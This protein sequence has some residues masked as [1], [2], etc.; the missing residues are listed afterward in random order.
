MVVHSLCGRFAPG[1]LLLF[2]FACRAP[3]ES[4]AR[5]AAIDAPTLC[6]ISTL[7]FEPHCTSCHSGG[8]HP[9]LTAAGA[10]GIVGSPATNASKTIVVAGDPAASLL[11]RKIAGTQGP[12]EGERM[13]LRGAA[14]DDA[15]IDLVERWIT[16]GAPITCVDEGPTSRPSEDDDE[17]AGDAPDAPATPD[18]P[19]PADEATSDDAP[20]A[21]QPPPDEAIADAGAPVDAGVSA[22][23]VTWVG[24]VWPLVQASCTSCHDAATPAGDLDMSSASVGYAALLGAPSTCGPVYVEPFSPEASFLVH[25]LVGTHDPACGERMPRGDE[26]PWSDERIGVV[27]AWIAQGAL[28]D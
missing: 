17:H 28:E 13:P 25:K 2:L 20:S 8:Q 15:S 16:A 21:P 1:L 24:D 4:S 18:E 27:R 3:A 5:A 22:P 12:G 7:V 10:E 11:F 19:G 6:D 14:L 23:I 9:D 26:P